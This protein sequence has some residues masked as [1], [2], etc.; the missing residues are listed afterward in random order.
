MGRITNGLL[1]ILAVMG[2]VTLPLACKEKRSKS[3]YKD[4]DGAVYDNP[5]I[6][7]AKPRAKKSDAGSKTN[8]VP[9]KGER[10]K[11]ELLYQHESMCYTFGQQPSKPKGPKGHT[12]LMIERVQK[13]EAFEKMNVLEHK[14]ILATAKQ[15]RRQVEQILEEKRPTL[16]QRHR[17]RR[18]HRRLLRLSNR[19]HRTI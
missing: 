5:R 11:K 8:R 10:P 18:L 12:R 9:S 2:L 15:A 14:T 1:S 17:L 16:L 13:I 3:R 19:Q 6:Q 7:A 4:L